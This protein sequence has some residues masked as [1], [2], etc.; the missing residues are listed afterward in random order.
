MAEIVQILNGS[1]IVLGRGIVE[2]L[3]ERTDRSRVAVLA[4][5]GSLEISADLVVLM[6]VDSVD[7]SV[8]V[9]PDGE[10]AKTLEAVGRVYSWL[11]ELN[12]GRG[13]TLVAIGGGT[14]T[15]VGGFVG[16]TWLRGI[17]T[18]YF[19]TTL[20]GAV[21]AAIGGKTGINVGGKNLVG[22]FQH[23][24][25]IVIDFDVLEALPPRIVTEGNAEAVKTGYI[26]DQVLVDM[27][28]DPSQLAEMVTRCVRFKAEVVS[29]DLRE[30]GRRAIL[31]YGHT[32]GHAVEVVTGLSHG[33]SVAVGMVAA[34]AIGDARFG[35]NFA[36][37][38]RE[39]LTDLDLPIEAS[40]IKSAELM[41]LIMLDKKRT[42]DGVRMVLL[43]GIGDPL[44]DIVTEDELRLGMT[45]IGAE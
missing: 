41:P 16:A 45:A 28:G 42:A 23:P 5:P 8:F 13:D 36:T 26:S 22:A 7:V 11:Q 21:D 34:A 15:D 33:E 30:A 3:P 14:V 37:E 40:G 2:L 20:T 27:V 6:A 44:V 29:G 17:E 25:R 43:R 24:E 1:E 19:T 32:I 9:L 38:H 12:I 18:V 39:R 10:Q 31:N 35:T 4:Q